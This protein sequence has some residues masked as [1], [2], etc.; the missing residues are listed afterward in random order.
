MREA[1]DAR[2]SGGTSALSAA[3]ASSELA[4][5][6]A[7]ESAPVARVEVRGAS[8]RGAVRES[9]ASVRFGERESVP[10]AVLAARESEVAARFDERE[11]VPFEVLDARES[12]V[13]AWGDARASVPSGRPDGR[14]SAASVRLAA[15]GS[16]AFVRLEERGSAPSMRVPGTDGVEVPVLTGG[17]AGAAPASPSS[18]PPDG[19]VKASMPGSGFGSSRL[20]LRPGGTLAGGGSGAWVPTITLAGRSADM[21]SGVREPSA[22]AAS[23]KY[24]TPGGTMCTAG[25]IA[26]YRSPYCSSIGTWTY[27]S[28]GPR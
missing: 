19:G 8:V 22:I 24:S 17:G 13:P 4:V 6:E 1:G 14:E 28:P 16:A 11:S 12:E 10:F 27:G 18:P 20:P 7:R 15:R 5:R 26:R 2:E 21:K 25:I 9:G 23:T 3:I